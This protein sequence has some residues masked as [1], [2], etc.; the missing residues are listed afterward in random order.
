MLSN[1]DIS[2]A[3]V[4]KLDAELPAMPEFAEGIRRAPSR[5]FRLSCPN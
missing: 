4:I 2:R 3:M 5:G 1:L